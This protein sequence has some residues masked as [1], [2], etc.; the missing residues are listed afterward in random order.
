MALSW[1]YVLFGNVSLVAGL[2]FGLKGAVLAIV[3]QALLRIGQRAIRTSTMLAIAVLA[4]VAIFFLAIPFPMI[5]LGAALF[6]LAAA[7]SRGFVAH[8]HALH[9]KSSIPEQDT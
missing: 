2:F 8:V 3:V 7:G 5:V 6:G 4:F 9:S 1:F